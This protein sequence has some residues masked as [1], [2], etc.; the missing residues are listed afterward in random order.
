MKATNECLFC[1]SRFCYERVVSSQDNG[2]T[3]DE[4]SCHR[5]IK[6]LH[7]HSDEK[8]PGVMKSFVSSTGGIQKRKSPLT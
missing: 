6:E 3:Y 8:A 5:H 2:A 1:G 4:V 7:K